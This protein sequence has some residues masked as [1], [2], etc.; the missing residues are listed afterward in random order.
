MCFDER[1][2]DRRV[3]KEMTQV[4]MA[5]QLGIARQ[6]Y[7][8]LETGK[9]EPR[10]STIKNISSILGCDIYWLMTGE[11]SP[12]REISL[13]ELQDCRLVIKGSVISIMN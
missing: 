10:L 11:R 8:D 1:L 5:I 4:G 12:D 7:L 9:T 2:K 6:T 3:R 13:S